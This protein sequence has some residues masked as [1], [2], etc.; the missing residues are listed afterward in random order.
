MD[1]VDLEFEEGSL[2]EIAAEALKRKTGA[3]ALRGIIEGIMLDVM[4]EVPS[5]GSVDRVV[6]P[7]TVVSDKLSPVIYPIEEQKAS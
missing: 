7:A 1:G 3:R 6:V 2:N 4:F 5:R